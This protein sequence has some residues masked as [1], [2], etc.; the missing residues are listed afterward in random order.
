MASRRT[1]PAWVG[2]A[3]IGLFQVIGS[4]GA[5]NNQPDRK[6]I[7]ALAVVLVLLGPLALAFR[8]RWPL[9]ALVVSVAAAD[10]YVALGYPYGPVFLSV[11]VALFV[12]VQSGRRRQVWAITAVAYAGFVVASFVDPRSEGPDALHL[13]LVA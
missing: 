9:G 10:V 8:D 7:D 1:V 6:P 5:A 3:A 11:V 13:A 12:A 4:F 2:A